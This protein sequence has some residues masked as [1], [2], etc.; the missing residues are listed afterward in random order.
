MIELFTHM[1]SSTKHPVTAPYERAMYSD[2]GYLL[3][4]QMLERMSGMT[5]DE[6]IHDI[7]SKPLGLEG[8]SAVVPEGDDINAI[9]RR[10]ID[11][12]SLFGYDVPIAA[13][14]VPLSQ[15]LCDS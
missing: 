3:L 11:E 6:A 2:G 12:A 9:D 14:Y 13:G 4:T 5:Y 7:L 8:T 15:F 10:L 1:L